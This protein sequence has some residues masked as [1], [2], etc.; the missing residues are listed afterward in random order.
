ML[1]NQNKPFLHNYTNGQQILLLSLLSILCMVVFTAVGIFLSIGIYQVNIITNPDV[2]NRANEP[3]ILKALQLMQIMQAIG[4]FVVPTVGFASLASNNKW[5][6]LNL[7]VKPNILALFVTIVLVLVSI[8]FINYMG[9]WNSKLP[10][11]D[12]VYK[13]EK[14][15]ETMMQAFLNFD[16]P[17]LLFFNLLM[18]A[19]LPAIGEEFM[20]RGCVQKLIFGISRNKH[21]AVWLSAII[22]SAFHMQF[23]GFFPR[24]ILGAMFGYMAIE[25][26]SLWYSILGHFVNN[27]TAVILTYLINT[28]Q[29]LPEVEN[30]GVNCFII[31]ML[32][33]ILMILMLAVFGII[34]KKNQPIAVD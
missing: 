27:A 32:S 34:I 26:G 3:D 7:N 29:I 25:S 1:F 10:F 8:P 13:S 14:E 15:A 21:I 20:F 33:A 28:K 9:E 23:L 22:F 6:Y 17:V 12:W 16:T 24:M 4:L 31:S 2:I 5:N 19:V 11:P 18:M 30:F